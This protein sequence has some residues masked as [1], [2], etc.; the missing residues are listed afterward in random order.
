MTR[1]AGLSVFSH[2]IYPCLK[3]D[4][5]GTLRSSGLRDRNVPRQ[6][7]A[8][9][10]KLEHASK[11]ASLNPVEAAALTEKHI[12]RYSTWRRISTPACCALLPDHVQ[13]SLDIHLYL[14]TFAIHFNSHYCATVVEGISRNQCSDSLYFVNNVKCV[15][16]G[17]SQ[18]GWKES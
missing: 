18:W 16:H 6:N 9:T 14:T 7:P 1:D 5:Q 8:P 11:P 2:P 10:H 13:R 15:R 12:K 17:R 3:W 4:F